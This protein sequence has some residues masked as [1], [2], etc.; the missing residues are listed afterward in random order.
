[1]RADG[2]LDRLHGLADRLT[3]AFRPDP[4]RMA[5]AAQIVGCGGYAIWRS[6]RRPS[7]RS[8][9]RGSGYHLGMEDLDPVRRLER[10][11]AG[12]ADD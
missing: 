11:V 10:E 1:M 12:F 7:R 5:A 4:A 3:A 6:G 9:S 2:S 8:R